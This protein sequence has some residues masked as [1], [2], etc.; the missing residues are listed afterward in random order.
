MSTAGKVLVGLILLFTLIWIV[1]TA[2]VTQLNRNGNQTLITL[3]KKVEDLEGKLNETKLEIM[4]S[5]D[6]TIVLQEQMDT[7][8]AVI[9]ARQ[10]DVQRN[11]SSIR[12]V[13]S[14]IQY[15]LANV[16]ATV[17]TAEKER[18]AWTAEKAAEIAA[19]E[20]A[21]A[22][23]KELQAKDEQLRQRLT[24]LRNQFKTTLQA[25]RETVERR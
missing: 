10:N 5:K 8:L 4:R 20:Q 2:G 12:E 17:E 25:N 1:L 18:Q 24:G 11:A 13:L 9:N 6:R 23:V 21:R 22:E 14:R 16:Q 7:E 3:T 15:E 19:L